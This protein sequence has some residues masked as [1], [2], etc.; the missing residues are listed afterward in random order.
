MKGAKEA[1]PDLGA[2]YRGDQLS[3]DPERICLP[4]RDWPSCASAQPALSVSDLAVDSEG[5]LPKNFPSEG[6]SVI[7]LIA[8]RDRFPDLVRQYG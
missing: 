6:L 3:R 5:F 7:A 4:I 1:L 8:R 2:F